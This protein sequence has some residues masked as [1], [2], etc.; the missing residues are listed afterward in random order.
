MNT[1]KLV[2]SGCATA[3][4]TP[5]KD[6]K[7]DFDALGALIDFQIENGVNAL[8][9]LGTTGES[10]TV[11]ALEREDMIA[12]T[13][14]KIDSRVPLIVGVGSNSTKNAIKLTQGAQKQG[15]DALLCVT[16]YYNKSTQAGLGEHYLEIAKSTSLPL[17]LYNVPSRTGLRLGIES[18]YPLC[19][20]ENIVAIKE[21]SGDIRELEDKMARFG[22]YFHFYSGC[23]ELILP[24]YS[25]GGV[26][27]ISAVANV[28]PK[29]IATLCALIQQNDL[30]GAISLAR[31]ISPIIRELFY[32]VNPIPVKKAL[33]LMG[34]CENELRLPL[35]PSSREAELREM[36]SAHG[37]I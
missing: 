3:L 13:K 21:A 7:I 25:L 31:S 19:E 14:Y 34:M 10:P 28:I 24:T 35:T 15:A 18:L 11:D 23:D 29:K 22:D 32:E 27:V 16:P 26:G 4:V 17:I 2:F 1:K 30:K 8:V 5:F 9:L 37:I 6:G 36:L 12:F 33:S 20:I